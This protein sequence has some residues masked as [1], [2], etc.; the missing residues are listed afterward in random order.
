MAFWL[1]GVGRHGEQELYSLEQGLVSIS[2]NG[3]DFDLPT[4]VKD[5]LGTRIQSSEI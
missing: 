4:T 3:L 2:W 1:V 5:E